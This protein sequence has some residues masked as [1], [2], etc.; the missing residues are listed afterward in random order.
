METDC[1]QST[2]VT[3]FGTSGAVCSDCLW[4]FRCCVQSQPLVLPVL[5]AVTDFG[6]AGALCLRDVKQMLEMLVASAAPQWLW[7]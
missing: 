1:E 5:C 6:T 3:A 2:A 4:C 7:W